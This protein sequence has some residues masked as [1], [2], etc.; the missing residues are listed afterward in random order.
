MS[1]I[2][3]SEYLRELEAEAPASRKCLEK[4]TMD[5]M[6]FAP[7]PTAMKTKGLVVMTADMPRW[8]AIMIKD[9][10]IDFKTYPQFS[11]TSTEDLLTHFDKTMEEARQALSGLT[12]EDL[13][14]TFELKNDGQLL[15]STPLS[16]SIS[17]TINHWIHHR[18]Q[19]TVY[20]RLNGLPIPALYGPSGDEQ[21]F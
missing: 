18:G 17:N 3:T 2:I 6:D 14:K 1:N 19:L 16:H 11:P 12:D 9:N 10:L 20:M 5:L 8:I 4:I 15:W 21:S 13:H 7:H